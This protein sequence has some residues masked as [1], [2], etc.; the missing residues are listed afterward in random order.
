MATRTDDE[1]PLIR[2]YW[3]LING[4]EVEVKVYAP[5]PSPTQVAFP[6][7]GGMG[8]GKVGTADR[9]PSLEPG[10]AIE[11]DEDLAAAGEDP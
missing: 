3:T 8:S 1:F 4:Q 9:R 6:N 7:R 10:Y 11:N 2:T 5:V